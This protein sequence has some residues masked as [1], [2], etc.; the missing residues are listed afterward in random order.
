MDFF[1]GNV[2]FTLIE[3]FC[4]VHIEAF[5]KLIYYDRESK[6]PYSESILAEHA[7]KNLAIDCYKD[8]CY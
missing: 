7:N 1:S 5:L 2:W 3:Y 6:Y 8:Q 4:I